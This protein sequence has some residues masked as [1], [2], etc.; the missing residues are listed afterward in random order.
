MRA[1]FMT[2]LK[3]GLVLLIVALLAAGG[4]LVVYQGAAA[5][6]PDGRPRPQAQRAD[7]PAR[8][9]VPAAAIKHW[10]VAEA[11]LPRDRNQFGIGE[12]V[13]L[14]VDG[15][16]WKQP[17]GAIVWHIQG[18]GTVLP[19]VG[20]NSRMTV[21]LSDREGELG[22]EAFHQPDE[23]PQAQT[24]VNLSRWLKEQLRDLPKRA[25]HSA[26]IPPDGPKEYR[27]ELWAVLRKLDGYRRG[28]RA[29]LIEMDQLAG[30]LLQEFRDPVER[31]QIYYRLAHVHGQS[32][33]H[34]PEK[35]RQYSRQALELPLQ[36]E[37]RFTLYVYW[38]DAHRV[39][40]RSVPPAEKRRRA[41]V[42]YLE[43]LKLLLPYQ[44]PEKAPELP[45]VHKLGAPMPR[46]DP[47]DPIVI[48]QMQEYAR[49]K[50]KHD[51]AWAALRR[52]EFIR[53]LLWQRAVLAGQIVS[54]YH[55]EPT[56]RGEMRQMAT[57]VLG[58]RAAVE[59]L[60]AAVSSGKAWY[61]K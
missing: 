45:T 3:V 48:R 31:G 52:A 5:V 58:D 49:Q 56:A 21:D 15:K 46:G 55:N 22:I 20:V 18:G 33:L 44:L 24:D 42:R 13:D 38:G 1:M 35:V 36:P 40:E 16:L 11:P 50:E 8:R 25:P 29:S 17:G 53:G 10:A 27:P 51:K 12:E 32:G 7:A 14:W 57:A 4:G 41:A 37:Q 6:Q 39:G 47:A 28:S 34:F 59:R 9:E 43:G 54:V 61:R 19:L 2:K 60:L 23:P 26:R 30:K